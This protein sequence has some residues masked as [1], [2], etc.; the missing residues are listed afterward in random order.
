MVPPKVWAWLSV[1][2]PLCQS[3]LPDEAELFWSSWEVSIT[4]GGD[5]LKS[6]V[7]GCFPVSKCLARR[8]LF[9]THIFR[10]YTLP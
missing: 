1:Q 8:C 3:V 9:Y 7:S 5:L 4:E 2:P 6:L 10:T